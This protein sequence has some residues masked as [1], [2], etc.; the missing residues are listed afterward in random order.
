MPEP[1]PPLPWPRARRWLLTSARLLVAV[2]VGATIMGNWLNDVLVGTTDLHDEG[3]RATAFNSF[4]LFSVVFA[5]Q[6]LIRYVAA[7]SPIFWRLIVAQPAE[8]VAFDALLSVAVPAVYV[9]MQAFMTDLFHLIACGALV[10]VS[11][12]SARLPSGRIGVTVAA[13]MILI[14]SRSAAIIMGATVRRLLLG[15]STVAVLAELVDTACI[16][17]S[18]GAIDEAALRRYL[19][20]T[21]MP[22][23]TMLVVQL[24]RGLYLT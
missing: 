10:W 19:F 8:F 9:L 21:T 14:M 11:V 7:A 13:C 12:A 1:L 5:M 16:I 3:F 2:G 24:S 22:M 23:L 4:F 18:S 20:A 15:I 17:G 6:G